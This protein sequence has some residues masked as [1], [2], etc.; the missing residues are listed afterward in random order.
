MRKVIVASLILLVSFSVAMAACTKDNGPVTND[1]QFAGTKDFK[2]YVDDSVNLTEGVSVT[3]NGAAIS[4]ADDVGL[5]RLAE[6]W[7]CFGTCRP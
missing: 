1:V 2:C 3:N 7:A 6:P 5:S 4:L